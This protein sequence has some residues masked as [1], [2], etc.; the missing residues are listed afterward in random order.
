MAA[1]AAAAGVRRSADAP[2]DVVSATEAV[3][4]G[5]DAGPDT[6]GTAA[7]FSRAKK[8]PSSPMVLINE[9]GN[10]TVVFVHTQLDQTL[11]VAQLQRQRVRHHHDGGVPRARRR[12]TTHPPH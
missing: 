10:T 2:V 7:A 4:T 6:A 9:A 1:A 8:K 5:C 12:P 11:Q 3:G